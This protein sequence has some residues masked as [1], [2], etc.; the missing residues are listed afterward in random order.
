M[1]FY[2]FFLIYLWFFLFFCCKVT[3][4]FSPVTKHIGMI[5]WIEIRLLENP[6]FEA[7][8]LQFQN[9]KDVFNCRM[10]LC[11]QQNIYGIKLQWSITPNK[12]HTLWNKISRMLPFHVKLHLQPHNLMLLHFTLPALCK[13]N[14]LQL[15]V[16]S[17]S[18][19]IPTQI[20]MFEMVIARHSDCP[21]LGDFM[22]PKAFL[23]NKVIFQIFNSSSE[24]LLHL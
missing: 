17:Y 4:R 9:L 7:F 11:M 14:G 12:R 22:C 24:S 16:H 5:A 20:F 2:N 1:P 10:F 8:K 19:Y 21:G 18:S 3:L 13:F 23:Q 15:R 6:T